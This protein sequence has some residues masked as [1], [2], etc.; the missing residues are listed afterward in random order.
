VDLAPRLPVVAD[1]LRAYENT[2]N[3]VRPHQALGYLTPAQVLAQQE[4]AA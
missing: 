1:A 3:T 4:V 2:Y